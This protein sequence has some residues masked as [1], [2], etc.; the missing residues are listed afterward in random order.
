MD[1]NEKSALRAARRAVGFAQMGVL[2][3]QTIVSNV[4]R[5]MDRVIDMNR[6]PQTREILS[7]II[8]THVLPT[9]KKAYGAM[10]EIRAEFIGTNYIERTAEEESGEA[11]N[12]DG[13]APGA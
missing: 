11:D 6:L 3:S 13:P 7:D 10:E 8:A 2:P 1:K 4:L 12:Q 5:Q 9:Q